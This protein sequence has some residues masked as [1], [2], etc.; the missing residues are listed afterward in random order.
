MT[1]GVLWV[2]A[3]LLAPAVGNPTCNTNGLELYA[4]VYAASPADQ[5]AKSLEEFYSRY[6]PEKSGR[7]KAA[8][9]HFRGREDEMFIQM[10]GKYGRKI[11]P[12]LDL[13]P[14]I[15]VI[16]ASYTS[17]CVGGALRDWT[18]DL[19][20]AC[21][22]FQYCPFDPYSHYDECKADFNLE[23]DISEGSIRKF[24]IEYKC[25]HD[26]VSRFLRFDEARTSHRL[27]DKEGEKFIALN[28]YGEGLVTA[29]V[30]SFECLPRHALAK[31]ST[32]KS[33]VELATMIQGNLREEYDFEETL[34]RFMFAAEEYSLGHQQTG[35]SNRRTQAPS[36]AAL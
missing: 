20:R 15:V 24:E 6:A 29:T 28:C 4:A 14:S 18:N 26:G 32:L 17:N 16:S 12:S 27:F 11:P 5:Q 7:S 21:E 9:A 8:L 23:E 19:T 13:G 1:R 2:C 30:S 36:R 31:D 33:C 10:W 35:M 22:S 34:R 25:G 3:S